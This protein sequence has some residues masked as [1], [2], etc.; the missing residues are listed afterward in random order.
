[1]YCRQGPALVNPDLSP[2]LRV[3]VAVPLYRTFDYRAPADFDLHR[4]RPGMRLRVPFGGGTRCALFLDSPQTSPVEDARLKTALD[5]IDSDPLLQ[6]SDLDLLRWAADYYQHPAGEVLFGALPTGLRK[7]K[8]LSAPGNRGWRLTGR[9]AAV[10]M[11]TL[12]RAPRQA[13]VM[14]ELETTPQGL[15]RDDLYARCGP[16]ASILR[17]LEAKAW[18]EACTLPPA[19]ESRCDLTRPPALA[20]AQQQAVRRIGRQASG[21][22]G[23]LLDGVTGSGKTEV[24]LALV[25]KQLAAGRQTLLLAPEIALTP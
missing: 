1:M 5:L 13:A 18:V 8:S 24:Y 23:F 4:L 7:G 14:R 3:A 10:S 16:C 11:D 25:E 12:I 22:H 6:R 9:G 20:P 17:T 19:S 21:F 2:I 15:S